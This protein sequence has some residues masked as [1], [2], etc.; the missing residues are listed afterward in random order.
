LQQE[1]IAAP[2]E[3]ALPYE[4]S[5]ERGATAVEEGGEGEAEEGIKHKHML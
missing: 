3:L 1:Q 5:R 4:A 2:L